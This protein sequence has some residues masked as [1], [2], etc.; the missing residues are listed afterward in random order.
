VSTSTVRRRESFVLKTTATI[1]HTK[2]NARPQNDD[3]M[4]R[5][6]REILNADKGRGVAVNAIGVEKL[7]QGDVPA[8]RRPIL[9]LTLLL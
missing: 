4:K 7:K 8:S 2:P 9:D 1:A 5:L 6:N 3:G